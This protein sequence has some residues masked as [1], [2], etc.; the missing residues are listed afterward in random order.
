MYSYDLILCDYEL[1]YSLIDDIIKML[2][3]LFAFGYDNLEIN[4]MVEE[5]INGNYDILEDVLRLLNQNLP[6]LNLGVASYVAY[7]Q[8]M[9]PS[10]YIDGNVDLR[11][12]YYVES[13]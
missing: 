6:F 4:A 7:S 13:D 10:F 5:L 8:N 1:E 12:V 11:G 9:K 2:G 3:F